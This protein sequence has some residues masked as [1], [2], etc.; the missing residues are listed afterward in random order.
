MGYFEYFWS[1]YVSSVSSSFSFLLFPLF[2]DE[3]LHHFWLDFE[4]LLTPF[5]SLLAAAKLRSRQLK[6]RQRKEMDAIWH[7]WDPIWL[8]LPLAPCWSLM[9]P[10]SFLGHTLR[11]LT[12]GVIQSVT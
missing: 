1:P 4:T 2:L 8:W 5:W 6:V 12:E 11:G 3:L 7:P 10:I 9:A